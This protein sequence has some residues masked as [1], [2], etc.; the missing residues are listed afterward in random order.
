MH[1]LKVLLAILELFAPAR[2]A[3]IRAPASHRP[4]DIDYFS[5]RRQKVPALRLTKFPMPV[6]PYP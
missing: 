3:K 5:K 1:I 2:I 6:V 4:N